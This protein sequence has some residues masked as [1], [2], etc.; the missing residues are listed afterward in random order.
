MSNL[1][2]NLYLHQNWGIVNCIFMKILKYKKNKNLI[3]IGKLIL[4][5]HDMYNILLHF[6]TVLAM[7]HRF[8]LYKG[9]GCISLWVSHANVTSCITMN[10]ASEQR[11]TRRH[12]IETHSAS[13]DAIKQTTDNRSDQMRC[14]ARPFWLRRRTQKP[15]MNCKCIQ[16]AQTRVQCKLLQR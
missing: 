7:L 9:I 12:D 8:P 1:T 10:D 13:L 15:L 6:F 3:F 16:Q 11:F 5:K 2:P 4:H 14:L